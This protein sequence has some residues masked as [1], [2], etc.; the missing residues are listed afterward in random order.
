MN[1]SILFEYLGQY[2]MLHDNQYVFEFTDNGLKA[3]CIGLYNLPLKIDKKVNPH[4][5]KMVEKIGLYFETRLNTGLNGN[6][7][8]G[9]EFWDGYVFSTFYK[10]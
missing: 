10:A 6:V 4:I 5:Q 8:K 2:F 3:I 9:S 1:D 7:S